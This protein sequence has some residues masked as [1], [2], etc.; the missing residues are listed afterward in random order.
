MK[1]SEKITAFTAGF[2]GYPLLELLWR[3]H[4]HWSMAWAGGLA[5]LALFPCAQS[6]PLRFCLR[7]ALVITA[8]ELVFG[9]LFNIILKANV[10][11]YSKIRWNLWGQI[12][13]PF[14]C[15]WFLLG[16]PI[17]WLCRA[18]EKLCKDMD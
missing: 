8:I 15:L 3:R 4:T 13:L 16:L 12:C 9:V 10:W 7:A 14:A 17:R 5:M 6:K 1:E 11:D 18:I 2:A